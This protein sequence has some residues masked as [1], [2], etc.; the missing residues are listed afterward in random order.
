MKFISVI[1]EL[2]GTKIITHSKKANLRI[3]FVFFS[4][5]FFWIYN[6][7][8]EFHGVG[9]CITF[10]HPQR[11]RFP[12]PGNIGLSWSIVPFSATGP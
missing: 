8:G 3:L 10:Q 5:V 4:R 6:F 12:H 7:Q 2:E 1:F 11:G 9:S